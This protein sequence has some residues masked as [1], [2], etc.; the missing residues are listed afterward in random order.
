MLLADVSQPSAPAWAFF[1]AITIGI[2]GVIAQQLKARSDLKAIK[3]QTGEAKVEASKA[4]QSA[5]TA[6]TNT[7]NVGNGFAGRMDR[8]LDEIAGGQEAL[9][10]L[11][12]SVDDRLSQHLQWHLEQESKKHGDAT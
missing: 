5:T 2:I 3:A 12:T 6:A 7:K 9:L 8:K 11:V 10:S 4:H 1:T